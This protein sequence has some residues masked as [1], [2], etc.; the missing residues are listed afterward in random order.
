MADFIAFE[1]VN[2]VEKGRQDT[3]VVDSFFLENGN[4]K[5]E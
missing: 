3:G 1:R 4:R 5:K 2:T